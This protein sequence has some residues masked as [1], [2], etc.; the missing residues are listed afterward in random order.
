MQLLGVGSRAW[1]SHRLAYPMEGHRTLAL[2]RGGV[3]VL[4]AGVVGLAAIAL[5]AAALIPSGGSGGTKRFTIAAVA[6]HVSTT[7][8][9]PST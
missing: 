2:A 3:G 8:G 1:Q 5:V 4:L 7:N 9:L 6:G